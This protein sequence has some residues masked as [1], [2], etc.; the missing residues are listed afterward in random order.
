M[1]WGF[2]IFLFIVFIV[3]ITFFNETEKLLWLL[4]KVSDYLLS[5]RQLSVGYMTFW[6]IFYQQPSNFC[7]FKVF[8]MLTTFNWV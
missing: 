2:R 7:K 3:G 8:K 6:F 1:K 4:Q 5:T